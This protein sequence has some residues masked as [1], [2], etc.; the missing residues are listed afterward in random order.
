[1]IVDIGINSCARPD[2]LKVAIG[3]FLKHAK[4]EHQFRIV[5]LEDKVDDDK[6][7]LKGRLWLEEYSCLFDEVIYSEKK[8]TYV[9]A[10]SELLK[11]LMGN[12]FFHLEDDV[13]FVRDFDFECMLSLANRSYYNPCQVILKRENH[14]RSNSVTNYKHDYFKNEFCSI[15]TGFFNLEQI[16][17]IVSDCN[18][19][20][21]ETKDLTP[22]MI[23]NKFFSVVHDKYDYDYIHMGEKLNCNKGEYNL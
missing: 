6:R 4:S 18:G 15:G 20:C 17:K 22:A 16:N 2:L 13:K 23:N 1:M 5:L 12:V 10:F 9:Y 21:H 19:S 14:N 3:T 7:Q 8:L 11:Y